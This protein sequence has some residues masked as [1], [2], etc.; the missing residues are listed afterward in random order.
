MS[1]LHTVNKSPFEKT[2]LTTCLGHLSAGAAVLL[3]EDGVYAALTQT[4][5]EGQVK[6]ALDSV[7]VY[8]LGPD[9][10]ARGL[11]EERV[12]PGISVVDYAGFVDLAAEHDKVQAWL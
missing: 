6:G 1:T 7:K 11:S 12:I 4:S 2:S 8:A 5:V 9:L 3:L 10:Q